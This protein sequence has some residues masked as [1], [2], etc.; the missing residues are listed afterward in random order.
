MS[1]VTSINY[2]ED[3]KENSSLKGHRKE[4]EEDSI[5]KQ[6]DFGV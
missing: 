3:K 6:E 2:V 4:R 1:I 5:K